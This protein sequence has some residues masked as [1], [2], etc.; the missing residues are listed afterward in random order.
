ML[1]KLDAVPLAPERVGGSFFSGGALTAA[2]L[3]L[4]PPETGAVIL[5]DF[6]RVFLTEKMWDDFSA[7]HTVYFKRRIELRFICVICYD[8]TRAEFLAALNCDAAR[9]YIIFNPYEAAND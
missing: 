2:S 3:T 1:A 9:R 7:R 6:T 4:I 5:E 8:V